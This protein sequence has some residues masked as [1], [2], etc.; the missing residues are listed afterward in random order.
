MFEDLEVAPLRRQRAGPPRRG[1]R[2]MLPISTCSR[3]YPAERQTI[4]RVRLAIN[5]AAKLLVRRER[6]RR[7]TPLAAAGYQQDT[8]V[9]GSLD[10]AATLYSGQAFRWH[11]I[12]D[13]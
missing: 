5:G 12:A 7:A 3:I 4:P 11:R 1:K 2:R 9:Q 8:R 10:L 6:T 13:G